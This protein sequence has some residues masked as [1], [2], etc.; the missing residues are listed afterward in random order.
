[1][2]LING[3]R[4][5]G[6][7]TALIKY[8]YENNALILCHSIANKNYIINLAKTM[9]LDIIN[10]RTFKEYMFNGSKIYDTKAINGISLKIDPHIKIVVDDID[11]CLTSILGQ[12][13]DCATGTIQI[14]NLNNI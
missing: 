4:S 5:S 8:A 9:N 3:N 12:H 10:P 11:C 7:T 14:E 6:K 13:I 2:K 1:M